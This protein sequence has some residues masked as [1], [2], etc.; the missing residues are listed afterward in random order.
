MG[1]TLANRVSHGLNGLAREADVKWRRIARVAA[2][3]AALAI[4]G[5]HNLQPIDTAPLD[6]AGMTYDA[7]V[8]LKTLKVTAPEVAQIATAR[9]SGFS[10]EAC[11]QVVRI[12]RGRKQAFD[13]GD[14]ISGLVQAG[15]GENTIVQLAQVNQLGLAAGELEAMK[16]A[17]LSDQIILDVAQHHAAGQ[18]VLSGVSLAVLQNAGMRESTL[19]DLVQH[20]VPDSQTNA[21]LALRRHGANDKEILRHFTGS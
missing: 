17:G 2:L 6:S 16:L 8:Q 4:A 21:I 15:M 3:A 11:L 5:C 20:S 1:F 12:Y 10:D 19:L 9:R 18:P 14:A 7:V 13:A